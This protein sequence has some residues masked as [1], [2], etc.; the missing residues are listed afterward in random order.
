MDLIYRGLTVTLL[1]YYGRSLWTLFIAAEL[2]RYYAITL[3]RTLF[4]D[5]VYRGLTVTLLRYYG[6]SLWTL[7]YRGLTVTL[8]RYYGRSLWTLFIAA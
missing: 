7:I 8:L 5:F 3:L 1:R 2:L 4:V 6:R